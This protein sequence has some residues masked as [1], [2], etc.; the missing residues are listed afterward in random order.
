MDH[1][2]KAKN[3]LLR[4]YLSIVAGGVLSKTSFSPVTPPN[5]SELVSYKGDVCS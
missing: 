3:S 5:V 4:L 2:P 1:H